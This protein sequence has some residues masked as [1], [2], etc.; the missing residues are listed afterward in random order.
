M[1]GRYEKMAMSVLPKVLVNAKA[2]WMAKTTVD[3]LDM[4]KDLREDKE[5]TTTMSEI[6]VELRKRE[7]ELRVKI[8]TLNIEKQVNILGYINL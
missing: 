2:A 7:N 8:K 5:D 6:V 4:L 1:I 3:N